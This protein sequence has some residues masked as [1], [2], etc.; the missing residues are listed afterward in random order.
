MFIKFR[1]CFIVLVLVIVFGCKD[2]INDQSKRNAD[3]CWWVDAKTGKGKWIPIGGPRPVKNG[4]YTLFYGNGNIYENGRL[5]DGK[6]V[7]TIFNYDRNGHLLGYAFEEP[8][9]IR[10]YILTDGP[11]IYFYQDGIKR[12]EGIAK[13]HQFGDKWKAYYKNGTIQWI[14]NYVNGV[15]WLTYYYENGNVRDSDYNDGVASLNWKHWFENGHIQ[16]VNTIAH[17]NYNGL[18]KY[19]FENGGLKSLQNMANGEANGE[20]KTF[21]ENGKLK[22]V[23]HFINGVGEGRQ[24]EYFENG[25]IKIDSIFKNGQPDGEVKIYTEDG[26][27]FGIKIYKDGQEISRQKF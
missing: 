17:H 26:K 7:D 23:Q 12:Y 22:T 15:G 19:Y 25:N 20:T 3:N 9:S 10:H 18:S 4:R 14:R 1:Y 8:D 24:I 27:L 21:Y 13:N 11:K 5:V 16:T 2:S 6:N